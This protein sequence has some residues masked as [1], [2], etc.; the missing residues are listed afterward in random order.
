MVGLVLLVIIMGIVW[1]E[2]M[3]LVCIGAMLGEYL[4]LGV[5]YVLFGE[6]DKVV[7]FGGLCWVVFSKYVVYV[8][9]PNYLKDYWDIYKTE[10]IMVDGKEW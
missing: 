7:S 9:S 2:R 6:Y 5:G 1:A 8:C 3:G 4:L 10:K